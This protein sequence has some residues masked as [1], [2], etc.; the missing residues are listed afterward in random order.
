M[1]RLAHADSVA[2]IDPEVGTDLAAAAIRDV[3]H[4]FRPGHLAQLRKILHELNVVEAAE[5]LLAFEASAAN[6]EGAA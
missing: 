4:L 2:Q 1:I 3:S 5:F 6:A